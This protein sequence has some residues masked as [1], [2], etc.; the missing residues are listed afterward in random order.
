[1]LLDNQRLGNIHWEPAA[2]AYLVRLRNELICGRKKQLYKS[3]CFSNQ[4]PWI[5]WA[6]PRHS[7]IMHFK[8]YQPLR[9]ALWPSV[10]LFLISERHG[11]QYPLCSFMS[12]IPWVFSSHLVNL[13][14]QRRSRRIY[15]GIYLY[16]LL[17]SCLLPTQYFLLPTQHWA[18]AGMPYLQTWL[19]VYVGRSHN[20][21]ISVMKK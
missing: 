6:N 4:K 21:T 18:A 3:V 9:F 10:R 11:A 7:K 17:L 16:C 2:A 20:H 1:M 8:V 5:L 19:R 13:K 15:A 12:I 14:V